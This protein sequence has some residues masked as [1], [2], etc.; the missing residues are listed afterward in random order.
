MPER[1]NGGQ[2]LV[3]VGAIVLLVSLFLHWYEPSRSAWTVFEAWD[4]VLAAIA[5]GA[6]AAVIPL[7]P[8]GVDR[9]VVPERWLPALAVAALVIVV[10][11]LVNHPPAAR[12]VSPEVGAWLALGASIVLVA[13][14]I[15]SRARI[16]LVISLRS[17][18]STRA[19]AP[20]PPVPEPAGDDL[21]AETA[22]QPLPPQSGG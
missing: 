13:G 7:R 11:A 18:G 21:E 3:V 16:S 20:P 4:L 10:V 1:I 5:V 22:T 2:A 15:L 19:E 12:G 8:S 17:T 14:A 9:H 6:I